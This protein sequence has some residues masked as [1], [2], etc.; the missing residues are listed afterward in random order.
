MKITPKEI[1]PK[2]NITNCD[3]EPI[4]NIE[5]TQQHGVILVIDTTSKKIVQASE[6]CLHL[7]GIDI[8]EIIN[9]SLD[10]VLSTKKVNILYNTIQ[11]SNTL[12]PQEATFK[13]KKYLVIPHLS[14]DNH[15]ILDIEP[16]GETIN[17]IQFQE[18][19]VKILHEIKD[20]DSI[21]EMSNQAA[22][23]VKNL[24]GYHRVMIY[25]FDEEWNGEVIAET[26]EEHL[27]SWLG[28][29][30]PSTDLPKPA[31]KIFLKQGVRI[32]SDVNHSPSPLL[33]QL[34][35]KI[36][37][38]KSELRGV[39]PI[40]IE[41]LTNMK[42]GASLTSA[43]ILNGKLWG[44]IAC[45]HYQPKF[46]NYHQR[47]SCK[48]LSQILANKLALKTSNT[49]LEKINS[50]EE[51]R[52]KL[53]N[54]IDHSKS[55]KNA[56]TQQSIKFT[57]ILDC[58]GGAVCYNGKL[59]LIGNTP[60]KNEVKKI[61]SE[62][63]KK[64]ND[65][66]F[67]TKKLTR[68]HQDASAYKDTAS[69]ILSV[70]IGND[71]DNYLI[72]FRAEESHH[73]SWGGNP[74]KKGFVKNGIQYLHPRKSFERW[75]EKVSGIANAWNT[76]DIEAATNLQDSIT[77]VI[78]KRQKDKIKK[79]NKNL[80]EVNKELKILSYSITH[81][82]RAPLRG[83]DG[84]SRIL[85]SK[86]ANQL[87][88]F[89]KSAL[90]TILASTEEMDVLIEDILLYSK[91]G[92]QDLNITTYSTQQQIETIITAQNITSDTS[93]VEIKIAENLPEITGDKKMLSQVFSNL[94]NNAVKYSSKETNPKIEI[95]AEKK[96][97][98]TIYYIK[99]NGIGFDPQ[100]K[101]KIFDVFSRVAASTDFKG[102]GIGLATVKRIVKK[103]KGKVWAE[104]SLGNG[105][106][107][108]FYVDVNTQNL[109]FSK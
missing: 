83:I 98:K 15:L 2:I 57:D 1:S 32:I 78:V 48:F 63:L 54:Q 87:D 92:Q 13:N 52:K 101:N 94:I 89:G 76:Y 99:D 95:G 37:L 51:I 17:P 31:R 46:I 80:V 6:N 29:H 79:L 82:L 66:V 49:F 23:L 27:E 55:I 42:V 41:Y 53:L 108:Y 75:T 30:Y 72:W 102:A 56:L 8:K 38:S 7:L 50:S 14:A 10:K 3:R 64:Q 88:Q 20:S 93:N 26:K 90:N 44:L 105:A 47:Q 24:Y 33:P 85:Q 81:D 69:G 59:T 11:N 96:L 5:Q 19:L 60:K 68:F 25:R 106:S 77:H 91:A 43:I 107:F 39:S 104:S 12:Y 36:D 40:H 58:H 16:A 100:Y 103:H 74:E 21:E 45:H 97:D 62:V 22:L 70:R 73:I 86:Y 34:D 84:Y 18:E 109:Q 35:K 28:L 71:T 65:A 61:I 67:F 9:Q 4:H